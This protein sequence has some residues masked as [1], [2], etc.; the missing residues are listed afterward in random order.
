M[1]A[2]KHMPAV[3]EHTG[4]HHSS[5]RVPDSRHPRVRKPGRREAAVWVCQSSAP[6]D[7]PACSCSCSCSCSAM[8]AAADWALR[9]ARVTFRWLDP[10]FRNDGPCLGLETHTE[11]DAHLVGTGRQRL[12]LVQDRLRRPPD[13]SQGGLDRSQ[14]GVGAPPARGGESAPCGAGQG[15][16]NRRQ[17]DWSSAEMSPRPG[18]GRTPETGAGA[19]TCD[20]PSFLPACPATTAPGTTAARNGV[21]GTRQRQKNERALPEDYVEPRRSKHRPRRRTYPGHAAGRSGQGS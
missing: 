14:A 5:C 18:T 1:R 2:G 10:R 16:T 19:C 3:E 13:A 9:H 8:V 17:G 7:T 21:R 12:E 15:K 20:R 11:P 4:S 6:P